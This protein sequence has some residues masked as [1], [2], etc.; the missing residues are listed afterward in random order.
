MRPFPPFAQRERQSDRQTASCADKGHGR[1]ERRTIETTTALNDVLATL[2][3]SSVRQAFR[4]TRER[5]T[6]DRKT[7]EPRTTCEVAY[8]ITS[9]DQDEADAARLLEL[10]RG[11]WGIEN[12]L[13]YRRDVTFGEDRHQAKKGHG[14]QMFATLRNIV[15]AWCLSQNFRNVAEKLRENT[16]NLPRL[17]T[18]LSILKN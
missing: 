17:L 14:P 10:N 11:H 13:H 15:I 5:T 7:G 4:I 3:W 18:Q 12:G 1:I 16:W 6:R 8:G 2:G 9:L